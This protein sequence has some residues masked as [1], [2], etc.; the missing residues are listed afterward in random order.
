MRF[1]RSLARC[2]QHE[3]DHLKGTVIF[4]HQTPETR[5][6]LEASYVS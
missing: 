2:I 5:A 6:A 1:C 4:D 3:N